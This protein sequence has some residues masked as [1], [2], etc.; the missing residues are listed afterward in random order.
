MFNFSLEMCIIPKGS[1]CLVLS[2]TGI[3]QGC[4]LL[5]YFRCHYLPCPD[6][7]VADALTSCIRGLNRLW[8]CEWLWI[9]RNTEPLD[10]SMLAQGLREWRV[11]LDDESERVDVLCFR[12][13][14]SNFGD[15][16]SL[17]Y[18]RP[19]NSRTLVSK[20]MSRCPEGT[21]GPNGVIG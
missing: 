21:L 19:N 13:N 6:E 16:R 14:E 1:Q 10:L 5:E 18:G 9:C 12:Y 20:C 4:P 11:T 8:Y 2:I 17:F 7:Q 3:I 15:S